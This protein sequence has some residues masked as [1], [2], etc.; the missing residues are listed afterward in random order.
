MRIYADLCGLGPCSGQTSP[1]PPRSTLDGYFRVGS[2]GK[3]C[4]QPRI[5]GWPGF[6]LVGSDKHS[7]WRKRKNF[8][9]SQQ[10][11]AREKQGKFVDDF[12]ELTRRF[13]PSFVVVGI[14]AVLK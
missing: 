9:E 6:F 13:C 4:F 12:G 7:L 14:Q 8:E 2:V 1:P 5:H 3:L 10:K 11:P